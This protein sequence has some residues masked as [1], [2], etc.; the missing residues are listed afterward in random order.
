MESDKIASFLPLP[1]DAAKRL[2]EKKGVRVEPH[3][4]MPCTL[5]AKYVTKRNFGW[6]VPICVQC[7][8]PFTNLPPVDRIQA[9]IEKFMN[10]A[11]TEVEK[12]EETTGSKRAR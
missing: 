6:H 10:L 12:V 5:K 8:T 7:S 2:E 3:G 1:E 11:N 9:E 4:P